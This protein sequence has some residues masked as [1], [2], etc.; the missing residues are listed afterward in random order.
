MTT[1]PVAMRYPFLKTFIAIVLAGVAG[2]LALI[3]V[4]IP[5]VTSII[6]ANPAL[7]D[8]PDAVIV[9]AALANALLLLIVA[10]IAGSLIAPRMGL[11]SLIAEKVS[12]GKKVFP[13][14]R[15]SLLLAFTGGLVLAIVIGILDSLFLP[16]MGEEIQAATGFD[17]HPLVQLAMGM[18][19][20]GITEEILLRW[21]VMSVLVWLGWILFQRAKRPPTPFLFWAAII[22]AAVLFGIAHLPAMASMVELNTMIIFRTV[23]LNAIGG[24]FYGWL[25]WRRHLEAGMVAHASTHIGFFILNIL[26]GVL[27]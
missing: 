2:V 22:L 15:S 19:Y 11:R 27:T 13:E 14:L 3:P 26:A 6:A 1:Q 10:A 25:F 4:T 8:L 9:L 21:G 17:V 16:F 12:F 5:Q 20:G 18:L 7:A 24:I 23:F